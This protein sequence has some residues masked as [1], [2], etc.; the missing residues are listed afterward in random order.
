MVFWL[1]VFA[2]ICWGIAP[3]F[4]KLGLASVNPLAALVVRT[5]VAA[6]LISSFW[7]AS[8]GGIE[9]IRAIPAKAWIFIVIEA[10]LAT[11]V[12]D[13]AY[14]A[15]VKYGEVSMVSIIM[16]CS[17]LVTVACAALILSEPVTFWRLLGACFVFLGIILLQK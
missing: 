7:I 16:S 8:S 14:Y 6:G 11:L 2:M 3:I 13:L 12:G 17:P 9:P 5:L 4:A 15:A 10:I 1:A